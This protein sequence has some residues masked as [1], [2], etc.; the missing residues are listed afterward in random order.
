MTSSS[1]L[2]AAG[3][4][5]ECLGLPVCVLLKPPPSAHAFLNIQIQLVNHRP[6]QTR[7]SSQPDIGSSPSR[8]SSES[9][10]AQVAHATTS[11]AP[12]DILGQSVH[13]S[14]VS[15]HGSEASEALS[16]AALSRTSSSRSNRSSSGSSFFSTTSRRATT[17]L[18]NLEYHRVLPTVITDAGEHDLQVKSGQHSMLIKA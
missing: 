6:E 11:T 16:G 17:P 12:R 14:P 10:F 1:S 4:F 9:S 8:P 3:L 5:A 18:Y 15:E 7:K 2:P 13:S